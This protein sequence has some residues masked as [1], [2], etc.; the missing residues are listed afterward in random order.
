[1][2][3][4]A[5][6][7]DQ[8]LKAATSPQRAAV[9]ATLV[10][11]HRHIL[12]YL[13][14]RLRNADEAGDV[15][16][17]FALRAIKRA[18]DLRDVQSV[19]G[20]LSRLLSTA[21]ADHHRRSSRR[22]SQELPAVQMDEEPDPAARPDVEADIAICACLRD[23]IGLLPSAAA[24]LVRRIDLDEQS[25]P[26]VAHAL[27]ISEATLAVRLHRARAKLRELLV[28]MCLTCPEHGFFDCACDQARMLRQASGSP[29]ETPTV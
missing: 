17:E 9:E 10:E 3:S 28:A 18:D 7:R 4:P 6:G 20:W 5:G 29:M 1:M 14:S 2:P 16:Q 12:G 26:N 27:N 24:D 23:L 25:R 13:V 11:S 21:I 15:M 22:R 19:R 8:S